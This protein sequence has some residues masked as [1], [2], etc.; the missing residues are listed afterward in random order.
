MSRLENR[1]YAMGR[2]DTSCSCEAG[3][4]EYLFSDVFCRDL[5]RGADGRPRHARSLRACF[6]AAAAAAAA[7]PVRSL[8]SIDELRLPFLHRRRSRRPPSSADAPPPPWTAAPTFLGETRRRDEAAAAPA[9]PSPLRSP[10]SEADI[11][12]LLP[13]RTSLGSMR[14]CR[15]TAGS[16]ADP[17]SKLVSSTAAAPPP[18]LKRSSSLFCRARTAHTCHCWCGLLLL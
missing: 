18:S 16:M 10:P 1:F 9:L 7:R 2:W 13:S 14:M 3:G 8:C 17:S 11:V 15:R 5:F 4:G 12:P 6:A